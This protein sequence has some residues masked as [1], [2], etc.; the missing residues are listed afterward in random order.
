MRRGTFITRASIVFIVSALAWISALSLPVTTSASKDAK[1]LVGSNT[2]FD[3][4]ANSQLC[5]AE[6]EIDQCLHLVLLPQGSKAPGPHGCVFNCKSKCVL[7]FKCATFATAKKLKCEDAC[8]STC[9]KQCAKGNVGWGV[10][11][12]HKCDFNRQLSCA[13]DDLWEAACL[14]EGGGLWCSVVAIQLKTK[15]ECNLC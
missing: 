12:P 10:P 7:H 13:G 8:E 6:N 1:E 5:A 14:A 11:I 4:Y 15:D 9:Q 3:G 2:S